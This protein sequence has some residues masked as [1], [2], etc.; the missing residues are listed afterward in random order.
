MTID[1]RGVTLEV[2]LRL[3][4][5]STILA[6]I[7]VLPALGLFYIIYEI[8][9]NLIV[10]IIAGVALHFVILAF[11]PKISTWIT[12]WLTELKPSESNS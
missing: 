3:I 9:G 1:S 6:M 5:V 10:G 11:S 12:S 8:S 2:L 4:W 7:F